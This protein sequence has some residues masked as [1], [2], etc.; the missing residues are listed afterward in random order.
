MKEVPRTLSELHSYVKTS[1]M[2]VAGMHVGEITERPPLPVREAT[3]AALDHDPLG[4]T[5][6][7][8][9]L[10]L[11]AHI[12]RD[13][14]ERKGIPNCSPDHIV[15]CPGVK[16]GLFYVFRH[17]VK[18][19]E[20]LSTGMEIILPSP[21]W[22]AYE[23]QL[24]E[25]GVTVVPTPL[26]PEGTL[27]IENIQTILTPRTR[28]IVLCTPHNP[29][30]GILPKQNIMDLGDILPAHIKIISDEIYD[31]LDYEHCHTAVAS[32]LP[33]RTYTLG[34]FSKLYCMTGYRLG[35]IST[36]TRK[37]AMEITR[38]QANLCTC[39]NSLAQQTA[40]RLMESNYAASDTVQKMVACLDRRRR[41]LI[42][43][44]GSSIVGCPRGA[45]YIWIRVP[46][47]Q[48][49][50]DTSDSGPSSDLVLCMKLLETGVA[51]AAGSYFNCP[52]HIRISYACTEK[53]YEKGM[54]AFQKLSWIHCHSV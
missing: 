37:D 34:G 45:F 30:G 15:C 18:Q 38:L 23:T 16:Q 13:I 24:R 1:S 6:A 20:N 43:L 51:I 3:M 27:D 46:D 17:L 47:N 5:E 40:L 31:G 53:D 36:P 14:L 44:F 42:A 7:G 41:E 9:I 28:A 52:G 11:R 8:G 39:P 48:G 33:T 25:L 54:S 21:Y 2:T 29:T 4:Y 49:I 12:A 26:T 32:I 19:M 50:K 10:A 22:G 35:W